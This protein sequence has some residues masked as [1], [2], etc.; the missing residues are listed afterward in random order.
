M[1]IK[2]GDEWKTIFWSKYSHFK[3]KVMLFGLTNASAI[4]QY[5]MNDTFRE[6]LDNFMIIYLDDI[7]VY[8]C[9]EEDHKYHV[10]LLLKKLRE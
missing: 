5:K 10:Q 4:F 7:L 3:Y 2:E 6:Y 1:K 9:N 8:S